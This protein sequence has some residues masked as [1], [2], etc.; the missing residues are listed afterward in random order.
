MDELKNSYKNWLQDEIQDPAVKSA[1]E[2]FFRERF[3]KPQAGPSPWKAV[4][5]S[6]S[7]RLALVGCLALLVMVKIGAFETAGPPVSQTPSVSSDEAL[8]ST[9]STAN[10]SVVEAV[11][12]ASEN[13]IEIKKLGSQMG[14]TVAYQKHFSD[15]DITV[16][17]VFPQGA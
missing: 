16:L 17:W 7:L 4:S 1:K 14:P 2:A 13:R 9:V 10:H 8:V 15:V 6:P 12:P 3:P 11:S 5:F